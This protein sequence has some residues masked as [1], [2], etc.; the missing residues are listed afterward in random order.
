MK[1]AQ[2]QAKRDAIE[3]AKARIE[4]ERK[5]DQDEQSRL[6]KALAD[7]LTEARQL[8]DQV[9]A[10]KSE[11]ERLE[12]ADRA[13][14]AAAAAARAAHEAATQRAASKERDRKAKLERCKNADDPLCG[15]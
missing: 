7:R 1:R 5:K 10:A 14:A 8:E 15:M 4:A 6:Q 9:N 12:L 13:K 2:E 11:K 3:Q